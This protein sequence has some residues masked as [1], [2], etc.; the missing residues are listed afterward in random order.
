MTATD[1]NG[2]SVIGTSANSQAQPIMV[3]VNGDRAKTRA[4]T[5]HQLVVERQLGEAKIATA[6]NGEF[7]P[8]GARSRT[9][10][11]DGD[12]IEIVAPRQGG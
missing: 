12:A 11:Q 6:L 4:Q 1:N 5:L 3:I 8:A 10:L 7:I 2:D 9:S